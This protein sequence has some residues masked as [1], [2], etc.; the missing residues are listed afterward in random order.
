M[1]DTTLTGPWNG[2][3]PGPR[4]ADRVPPGWDDRP[5]PRFTLTPVAPLIG[6][7]VEGVD[8]ADPVDADLFGQLDQALLEWKVLFFRD[9]T[10][11]R[12][13]AGGL[14]RRPGA[15]SRRTRSTVGSPAP[16]PTPPRSCASRRDST[17]AGSRT[18][19]TAT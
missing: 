4:L 6:A 13:A 2:Y 14:R 9:Q 12:R 16:R 19:G 11:N 1:L 8:L 17:S 7:V 3:L 5:T 10:I 15:R 18:C